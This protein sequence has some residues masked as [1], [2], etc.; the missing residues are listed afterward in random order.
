[1][2]QSHTPIATPKAWRSW[3]WAY[4]PCSSPPYPP[5]ASKATPGKASPDQARR[6]PGLRSRA[7]YG[8]QGYFRLR[9]GLQ[10]PRGEGLRLRQPY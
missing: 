6:T 2:T 4:W 3:Q 5:S 7:A 10:L 8:S 9:I 1:M